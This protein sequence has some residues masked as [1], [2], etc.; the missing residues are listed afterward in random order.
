MTIEHVSHDILRVD[1]EIKL[2]DAMIGLLG[3]PLDSAQDSEDDAGMNAEAF[4]V[5][6]LGCGCTRIKDGAT[7]RGADFMKVPATSADSRWDVIV[8]HSEVG[9]QAELNLLTEV[10]RQVEGIS[11]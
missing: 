11:L 8:I 7:G 10:F 2:D 1:I 3:R 9:S 4:S 6:V 5:E